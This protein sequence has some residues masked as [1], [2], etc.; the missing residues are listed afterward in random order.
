[1]ILTAG[2]WQL[3][4]LNAKDHWYVDQCKP[5]MSQISFNSWITDRDFVEGKEIHDFVECACVVLDQLQ[6]LLYR[7]IL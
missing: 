4:F 7:T 6:A 3:V 5:S 2:R 1:M